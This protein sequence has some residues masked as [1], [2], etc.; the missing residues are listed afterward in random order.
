M[1]LHEY[2]RT[3]QK[4]NR[5]QSSWQWF[6]LPKSFELHYIPRILIT[7]EGSTPTLNL[8]LDWVVRN[9]AKSFPVGACFAWSYPHCFHLCRKRTERRRR[10]KKMPRKRTRRRLM[11]TSLQPSAQARPPSALSAIRPST[12]K[13]ASTA[14]VSLS[15]SHHLCRIPF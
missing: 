8:T 13:S 5:S 11:G 1:T 7:P 9:D 12:T 15:L 4:K 10:R 3:I 14:H 2:E 6:C